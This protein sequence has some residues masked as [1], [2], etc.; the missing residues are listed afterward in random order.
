MRAPVILDDRTM[1]ID[2]HNRL[3]AVAQLE[4]EGVEV[5]LPMERV[6]SR[7]IRGF[8]LQVPFGILQ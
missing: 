7:W 3:R 8:H 2:G 1:C 6:Q 4:A 5:R